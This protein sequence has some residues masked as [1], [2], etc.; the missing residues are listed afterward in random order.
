MSTP[1][2]EKDFKGTA[3]QPKDAGLQSFTLVKYFSFTSLGVILVFTLFLSWVISNYAKSVMLKQ[4]D[5]YS[6][7]LAGNLNQQVFRRFV[8]PA[9]VRYGRIALRN[10]DQFDYLDKI[11]SEIVEGLAIDSVSHVIKVRGE[12]I[13]PPPPIVKGISGKYIVGIA[14]LEKGFVVIL[15]I[16]QIFTGKELAAL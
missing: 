13:E 15:D 3:S 7:L 1:T 4:S 6:Q 14:K 2:S 8:L 9:V 12:E 5:D 16:N 10:P 11:V